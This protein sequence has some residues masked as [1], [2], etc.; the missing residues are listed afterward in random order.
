MVLVIATRNSGKRAEFAHL[1]AGLGLTIRSLAEFPRA[2]EVPE[3]SGSYHENA[4]VKAVTIARYTGLPAL[5]DDS[6][7]EVD[8]LGGAPGVRSARF[9]GA[10]GDDQR[11]LTLLLQRLEA[12]P[13]AQR[14]AR[15]RCVIVVARPDGAT[16][17]VEAVCE[18]VIATHPAGTAGFGY[19]PV[20]LLPELGRT[21]AQLPTE[22]K[23]QRSHRGRACAMLRPQLLEFLGSQAG[24]NPKPS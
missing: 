21:F 13:S 7:L 3:E 1:L 18:G 19:D 2:P 11:N 4:R 16:L 14:T 5:A 15:F 10:A 24:A 20:F 6:G 12:T 17:A 8:A 23:H 22:E 9:A